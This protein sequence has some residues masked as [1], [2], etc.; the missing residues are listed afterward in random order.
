MPTPSDVSTA[1]RHRTPQ[2]RRRADSR[3]RAGA[4]WRRRLGSAARQVGVS[5]VAVRRARP[6]CCA[7]RAP[8][9]GAPGDQRSAGRG[10]GRRRRRRAPGRPEPARRSRRQAGGRA[11]PGRA[12]GA[13]AGRSRRGGRGGRRLSDLRPRLSDHHA[14][15]ACRRAV[16]PSWRAIVEAVDVPVL[17]I[18]G[19]TVDNLD[20]VLA[21]GCAGIAVIS[22]ILSDPDPREPPRDLRAR[23]RRLDPSTP[24]PVSSRAKAPACSSSSTNNR[25]NSPATRWT[26]DA[27]GQPRRDRRSRSPSR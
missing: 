20:D 19:I 5:R 9:R 22:A 21:T 17:A 8:A 27:A 23:A 11:A 1:S 10:A 16:W 6:S 15:R 4:G 25:V 3:R 13:R 12:L 24:L 2:Q 26:S 18:G 14:T 7:R